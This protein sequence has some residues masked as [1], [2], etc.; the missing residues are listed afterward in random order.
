MT[1]RANLLEN[2][3]DY[4]KFKNYGNDVKIQAEEKEKCKFPLFI[5]KE[6]FVAFISYSCNVLFCFT[7]KENTSTLL[8]ILIVIQIENVVNL[9]SF[10]SVTNIVTYYSESF[11]IEK[12]TFLCYFRMYFT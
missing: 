12:T 3:V 7:I 2:P 6:Y 1:K 10:K 4:Y 5:S 9:I 8:R 11:R